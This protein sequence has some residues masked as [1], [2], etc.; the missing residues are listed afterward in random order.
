M[1]EK[2]TEQETIQEIVIFTALSFSDL[3]VIAI[4]ARIPFITVTG[5]V[6]PSFQKEI[7][8]LRR[9]QDAKE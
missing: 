5:E 4:V 6:R 8:S 1:R 2:K 3:D 7:V 9:I